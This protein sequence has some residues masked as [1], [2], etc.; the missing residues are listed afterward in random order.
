MGQ[1]N[2][3][4]HPAGRSV[5]SCWANESDQNAEGCS[6]CRRGAETWVVRQGEKDLSQHQCAVSSAQLFI[7][8]QLFLLQS[9][10]DQELFAVKNYSNNF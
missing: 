1:F 2:S 9:R 10:F 5:A 7:G 4:C 8:W 6:V 3:L